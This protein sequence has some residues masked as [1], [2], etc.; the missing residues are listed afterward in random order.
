MRRAKAW[1]RIGRKRWSGTSAQ[2]I[3]AMRRLSTISVCT[4]DLIFSYSPLPL[5]FSSSLSLTP[6]SFFSFAD[7]RCVYRLCS[8][9]VIVC[10]AKAC[11]MRRAKACV[12]TQKKQWS[13][14]S[15]QPIRA[16]RRLSAISVRSRGLH[17]SLYPPAHPCLF[18]SFAIFWCF[19]VEC[20]SCVVRA[21]RCCIVVSAFGP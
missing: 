16:M 15:A 10:R 19:S 21:M 17:L 20:G 13:G 12:R 18:R 7:L 11:V 14:T 1:F 4:S 2:P 5:S 3:R 6:S 8:P 9:F